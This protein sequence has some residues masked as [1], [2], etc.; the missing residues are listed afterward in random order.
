[1]S[2]ERPGSE[3][4]LHPVWEHDHEEGKTLTLEYKGMTIVGHATDPSYSDDM[5]F[6]AAFLALA[7][8]LEW[9]LAQWLPNISC[10]SGCSREAPRSSSTVQYPSCDACK[11]VG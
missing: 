11:L 1:M 8:E 6:Y 4:M 2:E 7:H 10:I 3:D 9:Q 5:Q